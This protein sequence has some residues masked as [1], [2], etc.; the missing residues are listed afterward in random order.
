M[1]EV[2]DEN[3][4]RGPREESGEPECGANITPPEICERVKN[5][6]VDGD[7]QVQVE[8]DKGE[9]AEDSHGA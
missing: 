5:E 6:P 7:G 1:A 8:N 9:R 4:D 2:G 3:C